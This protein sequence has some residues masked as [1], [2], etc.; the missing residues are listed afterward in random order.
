MV[1]ALLVFSL[2]LSFRSQYRFCLIIDRLNDCKPWKSLVSIPQRYE[3]A[4]VLTLMIFH[5]FSFCKLNVCLDQIRLLSKRRRISK[6]LGYYNVGKNLLS[7][8]FVSVCVNNCF[9]IFLRISETKVLEY[10]FHTFQFRDQIA[11]FE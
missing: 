2:S 9:R 7:F 1:S 4:F 11:N 5:L 6:V 10:L 8:L 3:T